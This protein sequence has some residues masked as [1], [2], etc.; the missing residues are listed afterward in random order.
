MSKTSTLHSNESPEAPWEIIS[1]D[2][3]GPLPES[4]GKDAILTIVDR[5]S[6]MIHIFPISSTITS[7]GVAQIFHDQVFKLHS[8]PKKVISDRGSQFISSFMRDLYALLNIEANPSTAY[9]PQTDGQ[10]KRYNTQIE[11][12]LRIYTNH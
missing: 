11:Q 1:I 3:I 7:K 6:K 4:N 9:H 10:T 8:T 12:Y 5:F 2:I